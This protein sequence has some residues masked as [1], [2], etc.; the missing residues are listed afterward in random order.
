MA[1]SDFLI[2]FVT[3]KLCNRLI[4]GQD[5]RTQDC[6]SE[7]VTSYENLNC[8]SNSKISCN[9]QFGFVIFCALKNHGI[10]LNPVQ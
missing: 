6:L 8:L 7:W 10:S 4:K 2:M 1:E 5:K 3:D 9:Y